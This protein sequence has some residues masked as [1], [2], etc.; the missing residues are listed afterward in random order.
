[1]KPRRINR[2]RKRA[3]L[4]DIAMILSL[5]PGTVSK[6]LRDSREIS[7]ETKKRVRKLS[8]KLGYRPNLL[9]RS[10]I[11]NRS[12]I[13]GVLVPDLR[14]SFFSDA[15][16]GIYEEAEK[17]GYECVLLVHDEL[18]AKEK[19][20]IEFLY[21]IRADGMLICPAGGQ[22][23]N[24]L[25]RRIVRDGIRVVCWDR[26]LNGLEV[27]TVK[28]DD[29]RAA[30]ELT[31]KLIKSGR[32]R[33]LFLGPHAGTTHM[34]DRFRG[35][36]M[37]LKKHGIP[38]DP[39]LVVQSYR[40]VG[41]SYE[42]VSALIEEKL[43]FDAVL[44]IG[45]LV[46]YGAGK[47]ILERKMSIPDDVALAEFGDNDIVYRL[48]VPFY[49]VLQRPIEIGRAATDLLIKM[50]DSGLSDRR[51]EDIRIEFEIAERL[52]LKTQR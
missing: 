23:A 45:G 9:A 13:I 3:T 11:S 1:M 6:A 38:Y 40:D 20:K 29:V 48:G 49:S 28:I 41:D 24:P 52:P 33:V 47:A 19:Q 25:L 7:L 32:K 16:R 30:F 46:T 10:L 2:S 31:N 34:Q 21:D 12:N 26:G 50:L 39:K 36:K 15:L 17:K 27:R 42:K 4:R 22:S 43:D 44:S 8:E 18:E 5:D 51:F 14:I 35:Y 37:A